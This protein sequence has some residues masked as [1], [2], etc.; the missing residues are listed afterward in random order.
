LR[1][2]NR[3]SA[4]RFGVPASCH[5][6]LNTLFP[7]ALYLHSL[8]L[9]QNPSTSSPSCQ[10][11]TLPLTCRRGAHRGGGSPGPAAPARAACALRRGCVGRASKP[12]P[13]TDLIPNLEVPNPKP[14]TPYPESQ[15]PK[16]KPQAPNIKYQPPASNSTAHARKQVVLDIVA[17]SEDDD[18]S[19][20][21]A[22]SLSGMEEGARF[23]QRERDDRTVDFTVFDGRIAFPCEDLLDR[24]LEFLPALNRCFQ[25]PAVLSRVGALFCPTVSPCP[26]CEKSAGAR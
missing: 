11:S 16:L 17:R 7:V 26:G 22:V 4:S 18:G 3:L 23:R 1:F 8:S 2:I 9:T 12:K 14:H 5:R 15:T 21:C 6:G 13:Q 25:F 24:T 10:P 19:E 20:W